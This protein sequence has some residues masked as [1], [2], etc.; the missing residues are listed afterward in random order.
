MEMKD[1]MFKEMPNVWKIR[2]LFSF[3]AKSRHFLDRAITGYGHTLHKFD[4]FMSI[5]MRGIVDKIYT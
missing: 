3:C 1:A 5:Q 4:I 2:G